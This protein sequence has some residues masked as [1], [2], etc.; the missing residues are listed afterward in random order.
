MKKA[1]AFLEAKGIAY[2]FVDYKKHKPD[3]QLLVRFADKVGFASLINK[4][5]TTYRKLSEEDKEELEVEAKALALL[6]SQSS[7][8][9]RPIIEFPDGSLVVGFDEAEIS[10]KL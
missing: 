8:I 9:K 10:Q 5:G 6:G 2:E 3:E 1:F 4:K 7:M